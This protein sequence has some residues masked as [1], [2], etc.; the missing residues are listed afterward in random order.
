M[1][2][3]LDRNHLDSP[4]PVNISTF[5]TYMRFRG[6]HSHEARQQKPQHGKHPHTSHADICVIKL[7]ERETEYT[8]PSCEEGPQKYENKLPRIW[9]GAHRVWLCTGSRVLCYTSAPH[10]NQTTDMRFLL[11][12]VLFWSYRAHLPTLSQGKT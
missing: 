1:D 5:I 6:Q 7:S 9:G 4:R 12:T 8:G 11:L 10:H 3:E 2:M